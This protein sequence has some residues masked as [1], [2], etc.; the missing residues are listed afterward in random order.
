M[1]LARAALT[2]ALTVPVAVTAQTASDCKTQ[3]QIVQRLGDYRLQGV[4]RNR[5]ERLIVRSLAD[6]AQRYAP[7]VPAMADFV[8]NTLSDSQIDANLGEVFRTQCVAALPRIGN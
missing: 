4:T 1:F 6:H 7:A 2:L 3:G 5:A 8:Y